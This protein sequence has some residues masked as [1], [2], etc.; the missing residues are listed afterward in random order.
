M[1]ASIFCLLLL[2]GI[3]V[4]RAQDVLTIEG[5]VFDAGTG[6]S[7]PFCSVFIKG[8]PIGTVANVQGT[9]TIN[10]PEN[11]LKDT[12]VI[13]HVGYKNF[14][15]PLA[16]AP[17]KLEVSLKEA[18]INLA[19]VQVETRRLSAREIFQKALDKIKN[20]KGYPTDQ[21][22]MDGFY[23]EIHKSDEERT[24]VLECAISVFDDEVT[25]KFSDITINQFRKV[26]DRK[27][28]TD[29]FIGAKEGHNHL[30]LLLNSGINLIPLVKRYKS[31][32]WK[33]PLEI[34]EVTYYNDRLVY[35]LSNEKYGRVL[36]LYVDTEDFTVYR[37]ELIMEVGESDHENYAW[38]K[39]NSKGEECGAMIDHQSY[40]YRKVNGVLFPYYSFRRF[41]FRCYDLEKDRVSATAYLSNELLVNDVNFNPEVSAR[42]K[43]R[44][45]QGLINRKEPYDSTFWR[46]FNDIQW[47]NEDNQLEKDFSGKA[48]MA[49]IGESTPDISK[50]AYKLKIGDHHN[51]QFTKA[52]TLY[53]TLTPDLACYDVHH[54]DLDLDIA[55]QREEI[56]GEVTIGFKVLSDTDKIR[57]DLLEY[58]NIHEITAN[59]K[60]LH[61]DREMDAVYVY[62]GRKY[63]AGE[64]ESITVKYAGHPLDPD[65]D[66]WASGFMWQQDAEGRPFAQS[67]CQGYGAKAWWPVKNHLSDEP[68]SVDVKV[69]IPDN[70]VAVSNGVMVGR[71]K[72]EGNRHKYHWKVSYP[73]NTYNIAIHIGAYQHRQE[74][75]TS[76]NRDFLIDYFFLPEDLELANKNLEMVPK[77][78]EVFEKYFGPY[79]FPDDGFKILQSPYP[80]EHQSC[81]SAGPY[82][83]DVLILHE[84]AHEWWGNHISVSDNADI[85]I[86]E[87]FATY[88]E[89]IYI[90]ETLGY[91][92]GQKYLNSRKSEIRSDHPL[93]G[94][95]GVNHFH[96][97]IEDKYT[98][99]A[100]MLN[101]LRHVVSDDVKW[102][103]TLRGIQS[104]FAHSFVDTNRLLG[105]FS[106]KLEMD[107]DSFF[108]QYLYG[109]QIP[110]LKIRKVDD[111]R[112]DMRW[113]DSVD[114]FNLP[115]VSN[116][117]E[118]MPQQDWQTIEVGPDFDLN[119][120][121][122][123]Y[124]IKIDISSGK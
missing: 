122:Q 105:Y 90:E 68:D 64:A 2:F 118:V 60:S 54:Y 20:E 117:Q 87:A 65:F 61:F 110:T 123:H 33:L 47:V 74:T 27:Q 111:L 55:V 38:R 36:K 45:K 62:L 67:L 3:P 107:L 75:F 26:Y 4:V 114:Q 51:R 66:L 48:Q 43:F 106:E 121:A 69:T 97:R 91:E 77:V 104:R 71:T 42:D 44:K 46:Y 29:Q 73:I 31:T 15:V 119:K 57:I 9:F 14:Y 108:Q 21:F 37:N 124:L 116:N 50:A 112:W 16:S 84:T 99:G 35:V 113:E 102:F 52:D 41:H 39:L 58:L 85:W 53:G 17:R 12:L 103:E 56:T 23:R 89:S 19:E 98:K 101:T 8:E 34:K 92:I 109:I 120:L 25:K 96:Y 6:E 70:L 7:L 95:S 13:S 32:I 79:P 18:V 83:E 115:L 82:L 86:H 76:S 78:L 49:T 100:L 10:I 81:V 59:G 88:A 5:Q 22:R 80:M 40:E 1:R 93:V 28:N 72:E 63:V 94:V 30:L 24:G 11:L